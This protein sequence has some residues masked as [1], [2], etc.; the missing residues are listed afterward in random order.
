VEDRHPLL[1][2]HHDGIPEVDAEDEPALGLGVGADV[3]DTDEP[4]S[5]PSL[6]AVTTA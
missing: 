1:D 4:T 6:R 5:V 2:E 3:R